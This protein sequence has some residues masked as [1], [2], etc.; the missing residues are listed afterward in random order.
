MENITIDVVHHLLQPDIVTLRIR[1]SIQAETLVQIDQAVQTV[2]ATPPKKLIFDLGETGHI[3]NRG[4]AF[5][6]STLQRFRDQGGDLVL[7][8]MNPEVHDA[9]ELLDYHKVIRLFAGAEDALKEG[10]NPSPNAVS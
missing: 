5:V 7:A 9:F 4:W 1:G 8:A 10:F 6:L 3:S 2:P